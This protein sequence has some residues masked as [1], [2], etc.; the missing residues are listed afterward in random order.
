M[1][2]YPKTLFVLALFGVLAITV[3]ATG[4][5]L[6]LHLALVGSVL[7]GF[8]KTLVKVVAHRHDPT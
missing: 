2:F 3:G 4:L 6:M 7:V 8:V 1:H 5:G